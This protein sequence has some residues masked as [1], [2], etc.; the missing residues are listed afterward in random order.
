MAAEGNSLRERLVPAGE[1]LLRKLKSH[2]ASNRSRGGSVDPDT[3][4]ADLDSSGLRHAD[5]GVLGADIGNDARTAYDAKCTGHIHDRTAV[6]NDWKNIF[7]AKEDASDVDRHQP[8]KVLFGKLD[9]RTDCGLDA[10]IV[11]E[12]VNLAPQRTRTS[13]I[14]LDLHG[15]AHV[16]RESFERSRSGESGRQCVEAFL[17]F[18]DGKNISAFGEKATNDRAAKV[19]RRAGN[20]EV[21]VLE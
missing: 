6:S 13:S 19:A 8:V 9:D 20:N 3:T 5:D 1:D 7:H 18:R 4:C 14:G 11:D 15:V 21:L 17:I 12:A 10:S 16:G 2:R